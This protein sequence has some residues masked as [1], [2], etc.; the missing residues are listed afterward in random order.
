MM[1]AR[2][3]I[4][5]LA[6]TVLLLPG[7]GEEPAA[8]P[9][10]IKTDTAIAQTAARPLPTRLLELVPAREEDSAPPAGDVRALLPE[11]HF[12]D[13]GTGPEARGSCDVTVEGK[14][15][16]IEARLHVTGEQASALRLSTPNGANLGAPGGRST[17]RSELLCPDVTLVASASIQ[18]YRVSTPG[19]RD[20]VY[21]ESRDPAG[22]EASLILLLNPVASGAEC[23]A[24]A[25]ESDF[26]E[27]HSATL[28]LAKP[29]AAASPFTS[30]AGIAQEH[31]EQD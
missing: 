29:D 17:L 30:G 19:K 5:V 10:E 13:A 8:T 9:P 4:L 1:I 7:C 28:E 21:L 26:F 24:I 20:L 15:A 14:P 2:T 27:G 16:T 3:P 6:G 25:A 18:V 12:A 23:A 22:G 11:C 31:S